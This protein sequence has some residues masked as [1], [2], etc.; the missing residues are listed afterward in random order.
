MIVG[1]GACDNGYSDIFV[2]AYYV[3]DTF[4]ESDILTPLSTLQVTFTEP[5]YGTP[6]FISYC[7]KDD[8]RIYFIFE[9]MNERVENVVFNNI[10]NHQPAF[11][12]YIGGYS[13]HFIC[14]NTYDWSK[15]FNVNGTNIDF[16]AQRK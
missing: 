9:H 13:S 15:G 10:A 5:A 7:D 1:F 8:D 16:V 12:V 4:E 11:D 6:G 2:E 3:V 14:M